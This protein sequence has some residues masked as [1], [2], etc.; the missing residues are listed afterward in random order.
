MIWF[1]PQKKE[2]KSQKIDCPMPDHRQRPTL[3]GVTDPPSF[4][5]TN[6][7][8][9]LPRNNDVSPGGTGDIGEMR[10]PEVPKPV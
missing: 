8:S 3:I 9:L 7:N 5:P 1:L 4:D 2:K 6:I 10:Y